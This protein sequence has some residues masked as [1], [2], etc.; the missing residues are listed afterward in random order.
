MPM[1]MAKFEG[2]AP[3][4]PSIMRAQSKSSGTSTATVVPLAS[5]KPRHESRLATRLAHAGAIVI[6]PLVVL[7]LLLLGWEMAASGPKSSLPA[8]SRIWKESGDLILSPFFV[9]GP[10]DIGLGWRIAV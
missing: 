6:P 5:P 2:L 10:Q 1:V 8:P 9:N 3:S 7:A 4:A